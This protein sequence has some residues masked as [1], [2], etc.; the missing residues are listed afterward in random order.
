MAVVDIST[1][2][3]FTND[4]CTRTRMGSILV[5]AASIQRP[6]VNACPIPM[7]PSM[8]MNATVVYVYTPL[9]LSPRAD[10][11]V[12]QRLIVTKYTDMSVWHN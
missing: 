12:T 4:H 1:G 7:A 5:V 6:D 2:I 9:P 11:I 10:P 3:F 8:P